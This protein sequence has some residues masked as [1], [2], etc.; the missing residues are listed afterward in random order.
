MILG[1]ELHAALYAAWVALSP[2]GMTACRM[3][4][5]AC[6]IAWR[7]ARSVGRRAAG[8]LRRIQTWV[9]VAPAG[10]SKLSCL[11]L[12]GGGHGAEG[13]ARRGRE[14]TARRW[15]RHGQGGGRG[16][17]QGIVCAEPGVGEQAPAR[18][19]GRK[20]RG[21]GRTFFG[22]SQ[23]KRAEDERARRRDVIAAAAAFAVAFAAAIR[24][25]AQP[26]RLAAPRVPPAIRMVVGLPVSGKQTRQR[27]RRAWGQ[28]ARGRP[29]PRGKARA[30]PGSNGRVRLRSAARHGWG[31][32]GPRRWA[33][34][35]AA[36]AAEFASVGEWNR[37]GLAALFAGRTVRGLLTRR[38]PCTRDCAAG[39]RRSDHSCGPVTPRAQRMSGRHHQG[40]KV[41]LIRRWKDGVQRQNGSEATFWA[42]TCLHHPDGAAG[43]ICSSTAASALWSRAL[44]GTDRILSAIFSK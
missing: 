35:G 42:P 1:H 41:L 25:L 10:E 32:L 22:R 6:S 14:V 8:L 13:E 3:P 21:R 39:G 26:P 12:R 31:E 29:V 5:F 15:S 36:P 7:W 24:R 40:S 34:R 23:A 37:S 4:A 17:K 18:E 44:Y 43:A 27:R 16:R 2:C 9:R 33:S 11:P 20:Y 38:G 19:S 30:S 28:A